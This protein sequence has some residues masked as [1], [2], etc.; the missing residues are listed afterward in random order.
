[1]PSWCPFFINACKGRSLMRYKNKP[2]VS[3]THQNNEIP[4]ALISWTCESIQ[5]NRWYVLFY[6]GNYT[7]ERFHVHMLYT[8]WVIKSQPCRSCERSLLQNSQMITYIKIA[9]Y[10]YIHTTCTYIYM[11]Y[12]YTLITIYILFTYTFITI[13]IPWAWNFLCI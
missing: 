3:H 11:L 10:H 13:Y 7:H 5:T 1:M 9:F 4:I 12:T 6:Q 8:N 2:F